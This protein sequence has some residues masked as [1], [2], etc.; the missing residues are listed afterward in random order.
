MCSKDSSTLPLYVNG[1]RAL[2]S[3][4][5]PAHYRAILHE[6]YARGAGAPVKISKHSWESSREQ[7]KQQRWNFDINKR[8]K[9]SYNVWCALPAKAIAQPRNISDENPPSTNLPQASAACKTGIITIR[10]A[11]TEGWG[12]QGRGL[13]MVRFTPFFWLFFLAAATFPGGRFDVFHL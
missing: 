5:S 8:R 9:K 2:I 13:V 4:L 3:L 12:I 6:H 1:M 7:N 10:N 11:I